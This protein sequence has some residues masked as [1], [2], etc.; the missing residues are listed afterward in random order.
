MHFLPPKRFVDP[1]KTFPELT[2]ILSVIIVI[3]EPLV[4]LH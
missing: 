2:N 1:E 4:K 3:D